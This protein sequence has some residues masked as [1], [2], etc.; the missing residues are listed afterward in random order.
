MKVSFTSNE[1]GNA[2]LCAVCTIFIVS[3]IAANVLL[4]CTTRYNQAS[5]Q[6]RSW[7][8]ALYAAES[9]ADIAYNEV[10]KI[11]SNPSSAFSAGNGWTTSG[12]TYTSGTTTF[13][14][15]SLR[16]S[17]MV[18]LFY[19]DPTT[20]NAWYRIRSK[21]TSPLQG[22]KRTGMDDRLSN[23]NR[24]VANA[25]TRGD[26][27]TLLR[28]IDFKYDHFTATYGP[29]GD[30]TN[31]AIVAVSPA[32]QLSRRIEL[33][34]APITPFE[35]AIKVSGSF[36][37][38]G[39][40][41]YIDSFR[42][43]V[44]PY[45]PTVKTNPSDSRYADSQSGTVEIDNGTATIMGDIYGNLYTNGGTAT[46]KTLNVHGTIDNNVPFTLDSFSIP[47]YLP[48]P[49]AS[50]TKINAN[51]TVT[52]P[53]AGTARAPTV[54]L[55]S[56]F[57][58]TL[59][60]NQNGS[61]QTYVAIHLTSDF[62]GAIDVKP[63]VHVQFFIDGNVDV[64][65]RDIINETGYAG[66]LQFYSIS[67]TDGSSQHININ[68]PG[69]FVATFYA[70]SADFTMNGNPDVTGAIIAKSFYGN[71]NTS[72]HYDRSLDFLGDVTDYRITSYVEDIR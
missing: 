38:L 35:A 70:P 2:L 54:Y 10:R 4:N 13:G 58:K 6:V 24:F 1:R 56:S 67:P 7:N 64:K 53:T 20:G 5:N 12:T 34:A 71:G 26:G 8:E 55:L 68:S 52:P 51:T 19:T 11:A 69:D 18:D 48:A 9:G 32:P 59:T 15:N 50:P 14:T 57:D 31:K 40:A 42:S 66:N 47:T 49:Q 62:T 16:T 36:Y 28:K 29:T 65:A 21:G 45:D 17:E 41:A 22:L 23:G 3:V 72:W 27:D 25:S 39:S 60:I 43:S 44:G 37:G 30:G 46:K 63:G 33:I 61:S